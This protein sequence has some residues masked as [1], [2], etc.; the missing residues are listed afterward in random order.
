[1]KVLNGALALVICSL[2][3]FSCVGQSSDY[4]SCF[5]GS[6]LIQREHHFDGLSSPASERPTEHS[7]P[8]SEMNAEEVSITLL[9]AAL[10]ATSI[11]SIHRNARRHTLLFHYIRG[12]A[13]FPVA[14]VHLSAL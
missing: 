6:K 12:R 2:Q 14:V 5:S 4:T 13:R 9:E 1:M 8:W 10:D 7:G 11:S 3:S